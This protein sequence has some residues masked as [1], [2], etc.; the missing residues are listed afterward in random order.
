VTEAKIPD[1]IEHLDFEVHEEP[2]EGCEGY[3]LIKGGVVYETSQ[4][5][6]NEAKLMGIRSCCGVI[7]RLCVRCYN[8]ICNYHAGM[9]GGGSHSIKSG[10]H[11]VTGMPFS[12]VE[13]IK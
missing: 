11:R 6:S 2:Q 1:A 7:N 13:F 4:P 12:R 9:A 8:K 5:C 10:T 3:K